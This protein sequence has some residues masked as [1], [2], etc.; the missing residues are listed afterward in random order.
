M[1]RLARQTELVQENA[2]IKCLLKRNI[3]KNLILVVNNVISLNM[4]HLSNRRNLYISKKDFALGIARNYL[5][6]QLLVV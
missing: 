3:K 1:L 5:S 6:N 2:D 4:F